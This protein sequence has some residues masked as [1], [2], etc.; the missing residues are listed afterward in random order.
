[1][2]FSIHAVSVSDT[3]GLARTMMGAWFGDPHWVKLW[4]QPV[5]ED[6]ISACEERLPWN[7]VSGDKNKRHQK[8]V[9]TKTGEVVGYA[10]WV[11]PPMLADNGTWDDA[12]PA[13]DEISD[14]ERQV[15]ESRFNAVTEN[16]QIKGMIHEMLAFRN[17]P[18]QD[19]DERIMQTG[20]YLSKSRVIMYQILS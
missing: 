18:L 11:L 4:Y 6:I 13:V 9:E 2:G 19:A 20:P 17:K 14:E 5:L 1:M 8:V 15:F 12:R 16:G 7:L 3:H 10:R